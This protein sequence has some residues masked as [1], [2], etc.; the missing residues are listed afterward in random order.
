MTVPM[1]HSPKL[2]RSMWSELERYFDSEH[3]K[4][5]FSLVAFFL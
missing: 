4:V 5:I 1:K 2:V 3:V